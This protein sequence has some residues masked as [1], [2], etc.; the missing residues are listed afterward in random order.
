MHGLK[1]KTEKGGVG[2]GSG[3]MGEMRKGAL[4]GLRAERGRDK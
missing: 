1:I 4:L 2:F 3:D